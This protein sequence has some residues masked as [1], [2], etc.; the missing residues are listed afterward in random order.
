MTDQELVQHWKS[1]LDEVKTVKFSWITRPWLPEKLVFIAKAC[2]A[3]YNELKRTQQD[4]FLSNYDN[5]MKFTDMINAKIREWDE[6]DPINDIEI[7]RAGIINEIFA[8]LDYANEKWGAEFDDENT[9]NDWVTHICM[10]AGDAA[11]ITAPPSEQRAKLIKSASI[12]ISALIAL[13]HNGGFRARHYE[14][15][16]AKS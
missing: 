15:E 5:S 16:V 4:Q 13:D 6:M 14:S 10:Y 9:L 12:A 3:A 2:E 7:Q 8:E 11:K 1:V